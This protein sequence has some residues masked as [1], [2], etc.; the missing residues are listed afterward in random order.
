MTTEHRLVEVEIKL[1][2]LEDGLQQLSDVVYRQQRQLDELRAA[3]TVLAKRLAADEAGGPDPFA[4]EKPP[5]Y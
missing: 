4:Q 3:C 2:A 1:T 5:H